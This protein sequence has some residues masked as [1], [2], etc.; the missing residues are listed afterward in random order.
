MSGTF[1]PSFIKSGALQKVADESRPPEGENDFSGKKYVWIKDSEKTFLRAWIVDELDA[2]KLLV[3]SDDGSVSTCL[4][5]IKL[6]LAD[7]LA[8]N[9][10][11][12]AP[13]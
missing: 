12:M 11:S 4:K 5:H 1:A 13:P 6:T 7:P 3:Q 10:P 9:E 2:G 8:S